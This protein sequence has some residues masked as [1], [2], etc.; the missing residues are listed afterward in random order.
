[1]VASV[2]AVKLLFKLRWLDYGL[3][4]ERGISDLE[5][6]MRCGWMRVRKV[7]EYVGI[8]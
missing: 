1:V 2:F 5:M 6:E 3:G 4:S 7:S 8:E